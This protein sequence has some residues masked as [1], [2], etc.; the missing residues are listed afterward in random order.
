MEPQVVPVDR[1]APAVG[2]VRVLVADGNGVLR[3]GV[4]ALLAGEPDIEV[5]GEAAD[6]GEVLDLAVRWR[7]DVVLLNVCMPGIGLTVPDELV[8]V[9]RVVVITE[10]DEFAAIARVM[11][12]GALSYLVY[13]QFEPSVLPAVVRQAAAGRPCL[14]AEAASAVVNWVRRDVHAGRDGLT[15]REREVMDLLAEGLSN[16]DIAERLTVSVK[17]VKNH[18]HRAFRQLHVADRGAARALWL[19]RAQ[20]QVAVGVPTFAAV[21]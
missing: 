8:K 9:S 5:I 11:A 18:L 10:V 16:Q 21:P 12:A 6:L 4:R 13:G 14:T 17:T 1:S 7:P 3:L 19:R 2:L 15:A 20:R